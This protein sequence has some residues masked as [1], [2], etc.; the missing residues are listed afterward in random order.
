MY[1]GASQ[2][3]LVV[4]NL[5]GK[6]G[7]VRNVGWI[8]GLGRSPEGG[9]DNPLQ[10]YC[11]ENPMDRGTWQAT[12]HRVTKSQTRLKGLSTAERSTVYP[13][14]EMECCTHE[15]YIML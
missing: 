2:V 14:V 5:P 13:E 3:A 9:H 4:K 10:Y 7:D 1:T 11:L 15:T 6:A 12:G 8:P